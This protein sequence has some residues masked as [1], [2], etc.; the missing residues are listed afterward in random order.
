MLKWEKIT[1]TSTYRLK[2]YGG[3][4]VKSVHHKGHT[5][6]QGASDSTGVGMVF[7][8]DPNHVWTIEKEV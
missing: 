4:I 1:E 2:V 3:W 6:Y 5:W 8:S 7:I